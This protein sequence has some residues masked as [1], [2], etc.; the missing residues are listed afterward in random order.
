MKRNYFKASAILFLVHVQ[1]LQEQGRPPCWAWP[2]TCL[3]LQSCA[4]VFLCM[5][6]TWSYCFTPLFIIAPSCHG[7]FPLLATGSYNIKVIFS[8]FINQVMVPKHKIFKPW[9][10]PLNKCFSWTRNQQSSRATFKSRHNKMIIRATSW[11]K[12]KEKS[13]WYL[14]IA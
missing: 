6:Y 7:H 9:R 13:S 3:H 8:Y 5:T 12:S 1:Q 2:F 4:L 11:M 14:F 10:T